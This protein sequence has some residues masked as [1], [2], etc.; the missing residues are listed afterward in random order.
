VLGKVKKIFHV[1]LL[2]KY[3]ER[4]ALDEDQQQEDVA[5]I[6][7]IEAEDSEDPL[8]V[9]DENLLEVVNIKGTE[10]YHDVQISPDLTDEQKRQVRSLFEEYQDIFTQAPGT[11][12]LEEHMV[13]FI[14]TDPIRVRPYPVPYDK[15]KDVQEEI[16]KMLDAGVIEPSSSA[17][18]APVVMVMKKDGTNRSCIDFRL[19]NMVTRFDM[20]PMC[21]PE[22]ILTR[23]GDDQFFTKID[24][25]KGYWQIPMEEK[26]R[27]LT[28]CTTPDGCYQLKKIRLAW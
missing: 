12:H 9:D 16:Q 27:H 28:A 23:L 22:D 17:Y 21:T 6:A 5:G 2:R 3:E 18:T 8:V 15:R 26:S 1:N 14:T 4:P 20:E 24:L 10:T 25:S 13:E 11:T 7:I 19:L